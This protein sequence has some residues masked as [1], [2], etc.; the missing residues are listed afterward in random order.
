MM[1]F[2]LRAIPVILFYGLTLFVIL[3]VA[4]R[5]TT[6]LQTPAPWWRNVKFWASFVAVVQ[7]VVYAL[8]S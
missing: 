8:F 5:L 2:E 7:I 1:S 4:P 3:S 6:T